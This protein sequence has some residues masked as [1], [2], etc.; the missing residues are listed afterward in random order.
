MSDVH[1]DP[2]V[3]AAARALEEYYERKGPKAHARYV[4][5]AQTALDAADAVSPGEARREIRYGIAGRAAGQA[6]LEHGRE[7]ART[8]PVTDAFVLSRIAR[9]VVDALEAADA[10]REGGD[11]CE[12]CGFHDCECLPVWSGSVSREGE[13]RY[14]PIEEYMAD[15][16]LPMP[17]RPGSQPPEPDGAGLIA[18]ERKR[19]VECEGWTPEHDDT[20]DKEE[21][22]RAAVC[23]ATPEYDRPYLPSCIW[24]WDPSWWKPMPTDRVRELVKAGALIAAEIDRL[25]RSSPVSVEPGCA[26]GRLD[27]EGCARRQIGLSCPVSVDPEGQR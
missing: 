19:Q 27:T 16:T 26:C 1:P 18:I 2:R 8:R 5:Q 23:Y 4:T 3:I 15:P 24:P 14:S 13:A 20:H 12:R 21:L 10:S 9:A 22:A 11:R 17:A 6:A 25:S 7:G